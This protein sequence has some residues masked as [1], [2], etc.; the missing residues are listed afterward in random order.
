MYVARREDRCELLVAVDDRGQDLR[1]LVPVLLRAPGAVGG[2]HEAGALA[3]RA[4]DVPQDAVAA[5][6][7]E[8]VVKLSIQAHKIVDIAR[9]RDSIAFSEHLA[10][11]SDDVRVMVASREAGVEPLESRTH[12]HEI[13]RNVGGYLGNGGAA[14]WL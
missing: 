7:D 1:V 4:H 9:S 11:L 2:K 6:L 13:A 10:Q 12:L 3:Q 5:G 8:L 14:A